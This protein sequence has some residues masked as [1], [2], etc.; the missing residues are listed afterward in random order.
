MSVMQQDGTP[1]RELSADELAELRNGRPGRGNQLCRHARRSRHPVDSRRP[2][3]G[4]RCE[5]TNPRIDVA[6]QLK[7]VLNE[8]HCGDGN[9]C[10]WY[11]KS[12]K[13]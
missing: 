13:P 5:C 10:K 2:C 12:E 11:E 6:E 4:M 7:P 1:V 3:L 9:R 8:R